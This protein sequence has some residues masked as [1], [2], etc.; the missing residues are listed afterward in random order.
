MAIELVTLIEAARRLR[1]RVA[2]TLNEA[3]ERKLRT[4]FLCHSHKDVTYVEGVVTL[5]TPAGTFTSIGRTSRCPRCP[6]SKPPK[7][8][9]DASRPAITFCSYQPNSLTSRWCPWEIGVADGTKSNDRIL[10]IPRGAA[11]PSTE[12]RM[13]AS[14]A[15]STSP[16]MG[17]LAAWPPG[18][19]ES[20]VYVRQ[21]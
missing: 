4:A 16:A 6:I 20:G 18:T 21:L 9:A 14:T 11:R 19:N 13:S 12:T 15:G 17:R 1:I 2:A 3:R 10:V 5:L 8:S 7:T